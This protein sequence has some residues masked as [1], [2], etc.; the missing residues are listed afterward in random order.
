MVMDF[1]T[2]SHQAQLVMVAEA[3]TLSEPY[4]LAFFFYVLQFNN[5]HS[6]I[7]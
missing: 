5:A 6:T 2:V 7:I 3:V 4:V 1:L